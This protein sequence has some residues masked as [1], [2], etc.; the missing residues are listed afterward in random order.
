MLRFT[1]VLT[2]FMANE[3]DAVIPPKER[4]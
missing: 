3:P 2:Y 4:Y 1:I